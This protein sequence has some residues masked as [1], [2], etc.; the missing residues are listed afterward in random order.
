M[1]KNIL[2]VSGS[3]MIDK[4]EQK[5]LNGGMNFCP[6]N[7]VLDF[8]QGRCIVP[9]CSPQNFIGGCLANGFTC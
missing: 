5:S 3:K 1:L 7:L 6:G 8:C 2:N 4:S 9:T